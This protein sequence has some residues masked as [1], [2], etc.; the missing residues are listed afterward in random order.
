M[1][2][3][4]LNQKSFDKTGPPFEV[5]HFSLSDRSEFWLNGSRPMHLRNFGSDKIQPRPQGGGGKPRERGWTKLSV[6]STYVRPSLHANRIEILHFKYPLVSVVNRITTRTFREKKKQ[7][8]SILSFNFIL[9]STLTWITEKELEREIKNKGDQ[10]RRKNNMKK[11]RNASSPHSVKMIGSEQKSE[12][13]RYNT[14]NTSSIKR[15]D[16]KF[17]EATL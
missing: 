5:V 7:G 11:M 9:M 3:F 12:Q 16:R 4:N 1:D 13:E 10:Y 2:R 14:L 15:V 17:L 6:R 8:R